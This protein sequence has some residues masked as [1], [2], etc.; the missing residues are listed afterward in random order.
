LVGNGGDLPFVIT[1]IS[2]GASISSACCFNAFYE[3][4]FIIALVL[5]FNPKWVN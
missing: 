4:A 2:G 1:G 3:I 5:R